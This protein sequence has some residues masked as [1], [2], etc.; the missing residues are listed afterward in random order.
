VR[1]F[2]TNVLLRII[3]VDDPEQHR[4]ASKAFG[5]A[6]AS[7][8]AY[9]SKVVL[10]EIAWVLRGGPKFPRATVADALTRLIDLEGVVVEDDLEVR[11]ALAGFGAGAADFADYLVRSTAR[12]AGAVPLLTFDTKLAGEP[13][14]EL[15]TP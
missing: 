3:L 6:L 1:A 9:V 8:G 12:A 4:I 2:D 14:V 13:D 5:D 7:G 10:S 11:E 15:L